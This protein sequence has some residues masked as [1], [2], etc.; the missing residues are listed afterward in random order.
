MLEKVILS[1]SKTFFDHR[2][3]FI[4]VSLKYNDTMMSK[5]IQSNVS[6][7]THKNTFRGL[8]YQ[9]GIW[10]QSKLV[11]VLKGKIL[12]FVVD[13]RKNSP[14][15]NKVEIF[16]LDTENQLYIP[17]HFAHG[18]LTLEDE[19]IVQYHVD[20]DYNKE[21]ERTLFWNE[22]K[23]VNEILKNIDLIISEKDKPN[24]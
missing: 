14:N 12:D 11:K 16:T 22:V 10:S 17:R 4:P 6:I 3:Q 19:C 2:G 7:S 23:E 15:Y 1:E 20:N 8:H 9:E 18:F 24:L 21:M 5:W 13:L